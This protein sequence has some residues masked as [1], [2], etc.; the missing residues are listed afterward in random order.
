MAACNSTD[1]IALVVQHEMS[2]GLDVIVARIY[3]RALA[4]FPTGAPMLQFGK[5]LSAFFFAFFF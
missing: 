4:S 2:E 3:F 1:F 5:A